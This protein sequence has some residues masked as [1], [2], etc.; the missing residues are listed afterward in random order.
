MTDRTHSADS[1]NSPTT[2]YGYCAWHQAHAAGIRLIT[3]HEQ[4]SGAGGSS[5]A[6]AACREKHGLIPF[7]DRPIEL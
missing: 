6:C 5:Y 7:A 4:G 1:S 3:V 2:A